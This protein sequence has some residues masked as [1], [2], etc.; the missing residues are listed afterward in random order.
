MLNPE[1]PPDGMD[2][3]R[4]LQRMVLFDVLIGNDDRNAGNVLIDGDW[5]V[6]L[7]DHTRAFYARARTS[8]LSDVAYVDRAF[9]EGLQALDKDLLEGVM[10]DYVSSSA[11]R[12]ILQRRDR[13]VVRINELVAERGDEV[14]FYEAR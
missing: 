5:K 3:A 6:W 13:L 1:M 2:W 14:V 11:I 10:G 4:Q 12:R 8:G 9:F 7:I